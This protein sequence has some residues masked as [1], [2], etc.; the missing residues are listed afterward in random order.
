MLKLIENTSQLSQKYC[1]A[2]GRL[3]PMYERLQY[4]RIVFAWGMKRGCQS[5]SKIRGARSTS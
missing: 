4:G 2:H 5:P 3:T 1:L